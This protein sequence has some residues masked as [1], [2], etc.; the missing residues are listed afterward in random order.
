MARPRKNTP[1]GKLAT[2]RW[3][4][5]MEKK[6]G[7]VTEKM[8]EIGRIGGKNGCGPDYM[9]G[10]AADRERAR[11]AGAKGGHISRRN[12]KY[13]RIMDENK[14]AIEIVLKSRKTLKDFADEIGVPYK[15]LLH[16]ART[17]FGETKDV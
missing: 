16:Y 11:I 1:A 3:R 7:G 9:G 10:F 2:E 4:Q 12:G 14:Q 5:T 17:R 13:T 15:S 6:Y 8:R